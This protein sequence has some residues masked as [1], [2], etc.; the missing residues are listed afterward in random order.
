MKSCGASGLACKISVHS[1]NVLALISFV[2][3]RKKAN[4]IENKLVSMTPSYLK[5]ER[6]PALETNVSSKSQTFKCST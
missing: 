1:S 4:T 5:P 6:D 3:T 2:T